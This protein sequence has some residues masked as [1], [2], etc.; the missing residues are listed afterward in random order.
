[1]KLSSSLVLAGATVVGAFAPTAFVGRANTAVNVAVGDSLPSVELFQ[2]FPGPKKINLADYAKGKNL[3]VVGLPGAFTPTVS[4]SKLMCSRIRRHDS[5]PIDPFS[6][7]TVI[8]TAGSW[9]S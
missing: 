7:F 8:L 6:L 4:L 3:I 5:L 1:M 9:V 2:G